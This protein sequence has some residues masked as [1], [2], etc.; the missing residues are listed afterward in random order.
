L[1]GDCSIRINE[2]GF[3]PD[4][5]VACA[6]RSGLLS[7]EIALE[8]SGLCQCT[9]CQT[10]RFGHQSPLTLPEFQNLMSQAKEEGARRCILV[11]SQPAS[12]PHLQPLIDHLRAAGMQVELFTAGVGIDAAQ[13]KFLRQ[14][15]VAVSVKLDSLNRDLQNR[16]SGRDDSFDTIFRALG[17]LKEAGYGSAGGAPQL[18]V[19]IAVCSDN[20][21]EIP[22]LWQWARGQHFE[23]HVQIIKPRQGPHDS[24]TVIPP[25]RAKQ[26]FQTLERIDREEFSR[27]WPIDSSLIGRSCKRHQ[28]ACHVTGCGT[29]FAC[30]GITIPLGNI[31]L[32]PLRKI[33]GES[34]VL[35]NLRINGQIIKEPCR[36]CSK[37]T[38]C[39]GCRGAAYQLTG[40]YLAADQMC[41][42]TAGADI[43][44]L[45]VGVTD[46]MPHGPSM[47]MVT[48][49]LQ[50]GERQALT[51]Y[52]V[53]PSSPLVDETGR[54]DELAYIE[55][56]AQSFAVCHGF[57]LSAE[58]RLIHRGL[59]IGV[60]D[61]VV[62]GDARVG[63][64][65]TIDLRKL[66]RFGDFGVVEASIHHE[67]GRL[68]ATGQVKVWRPGKDAQKALQI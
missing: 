41:W 17:H 21:P 33:L 9:A 32:Q 11:D 2:P 49:L 24:P 31:R 64:R 30:V 35:E 66:T 65:L 56:I 37:T 23:P 29:I 58:E 10:S 39:Y 3:T 20:L 12:H 4:E 53:T 25:Q 14:R 42:K 7:F 5:I 57:P 18:A 63:D 67:D 48:Q 62:T 51:E 38:D 40:D 46:L 59:L 16:L 22:V 45:P 43:Q 15:E 47:R 61:L 68:L 27:S 44:S 52:L 50:V 6:Q 8:S 34:E 54:L 36:T 1:R 55:M 28:Y 26:L 13:A 19:R 60:K